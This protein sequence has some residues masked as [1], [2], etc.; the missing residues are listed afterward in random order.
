[1]NLLSNVSVAGASSADLGTVQGSASLLVLKKALDAQETTAT[2]LIS[3]LPQ[4]QPLA[5]SGSV[6]TLVNTFA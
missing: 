1:M 3:A 2:Q 4:A 6:G 5:T